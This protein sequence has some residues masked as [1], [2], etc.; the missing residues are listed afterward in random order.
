MCKAGALPAELPPSPWIRGLLRALDF[1]FSAFY[2]IF[3][4]R[5]RNVDLKFDYRKPTEIIKKINQFRQK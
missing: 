3:E 2:A 4:L 1:F 5:I